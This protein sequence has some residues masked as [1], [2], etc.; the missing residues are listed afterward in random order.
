MSLRCWSTGL[1]S[2][3]SVLGHPGF[4][5]RALKA[6]QQRQNATARSTQK[7]DQTRERKTDVEKWVVFCDMFQKDIENTNLLVGLAQPGYLHPS[8]NTRSL[9]QGYCTAD[10]KLQLLGYPIYR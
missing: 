4:I 1:L 5:E 3:L 7:D 9:R 2:M 8:L 6:T 10:G